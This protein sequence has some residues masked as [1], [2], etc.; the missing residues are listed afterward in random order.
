M[1]QESGKL[2]EAEVSHR[3]AITLQPDYTEAYYNLG[4]TLQALI[5]QDEAVV[6]YEQVLTQRP[7]HAEAHYNLG[8][9]LQ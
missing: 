2:D 4:T 6:C 7:D 1:L 5:R 9:A 3:Q 8:I